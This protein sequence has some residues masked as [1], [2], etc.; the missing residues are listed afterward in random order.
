[1]LV[2]IKVFVGSA[3]LVGGV[4]AETVVE[5]LLGV[6]VLTAADAFVPIDGDC[7]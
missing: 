7:P 4:L 6:A 3:V 2:G 1:M 5:V